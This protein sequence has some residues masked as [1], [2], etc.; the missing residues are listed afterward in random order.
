MWNAPLTKV[1]RW[2][3][4]MPL[5]YL[6][7]TLIHFLFGTLLVW[8]GN[9]NLSTFWFFTCLVLFGG[10][11]WGLLQMLSTFLLVMTTMVCPNKKYGGLIFGGMTLL[12]FLYMLY[13][14]WTIQADYSVKTIIF[15]IV[16]SFLIIS[17]GFNLVI[18]SLI[19]TDDE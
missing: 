15:L 14:I 1:L 9:L 8:V 7:L 3:V 16:I 13:S 12:Y 18:G 2:I 5:I 4:Y 6:V 19:T 11:L 10:I 17:L